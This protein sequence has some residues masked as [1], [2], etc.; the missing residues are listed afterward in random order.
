MA[1]RAFPLQPQDVPPVSTEYR[2]I[3]TPIPVPESVPILERL[4]RYEPR[5]MSGQP[6][7]VWDR[8]QGVQVFDKWGN[9]W[10]DFSSGVLVTNAGH[11]H[12][13]VV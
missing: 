6:P 2:T 9:A 8:A 1:D 3:R 12:P 11:S 10:L 5:S 7:V 13:L 4:R